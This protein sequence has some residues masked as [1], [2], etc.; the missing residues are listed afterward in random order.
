M[1]EDYVERGTAGARRQ[2]EDTEEVVQQQQEDM[3]H[4]EDVGLRISE[5][6]GT[7]EEMMVAMGD[8]LSELAISDDGEDGDND[9]DKETEQHKLGEDDKPG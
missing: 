8:S 1:I 4:A 7:F 9:D 2:V 6:K 5:P 3:K